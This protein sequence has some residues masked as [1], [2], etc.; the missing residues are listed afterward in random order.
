MV[1]DIAALQHLYGAAAYNEFDPVYK[2]DPG[3]PVL[4]AIW[5]SGDMDT[6][7]FNDFMKSCPVDLALG[8][9]STN[10]FAEWTMTD[11]LGITYGAVIENAIGG[12][13]KDTIAGNSVANIPF[14]GSGAGAKDILTGNGGTNIFSVSVS[15]YTRIVAFAVVVSDFTSETNF[16]GFE[17]HV[18]SDLSISNSSGD[19]KFFDIFSNKLLFVLSGVDYTLIDSSVFFY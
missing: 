18:F 19:T 3:K 10:T 14:G 11:N 8:G 1:C 7:D 17:D 4:E 9:Y 5:G 6:L 16:I 13:G 12:G 15:D 2:Y